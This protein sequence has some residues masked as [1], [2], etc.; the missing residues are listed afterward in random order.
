MVLNRLATFAPNSP[1]P[2]DHNRRKGKGRKNA[3]GKQGAS[4]KRL[5]LKRNT[6]KRKKDNH[7]TKKMEKG[8]EKGIYRMARGLGDCGLPCP[9]VVAENR[10]LRGSL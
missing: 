5:E 7:K 1:E 2:R 3:G 9:Y 4:R 10:G 8:K 6:R